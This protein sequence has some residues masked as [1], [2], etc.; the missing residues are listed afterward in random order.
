MAET[1]TPSA[2]SQMDTSTPQHHQVKADALVSHPIA[3]SPSMDIS[4]E[5][6]SLSSLNV[7]AAGFTPQALRLPAEGSSV[8]SIA[9]PAV[10]GSGSG[11]TARALHPVID[12]DS[13]PSTPEAVREALAAVHSL[14]LTRGMVATDRSVSCSG[15]GSG[16]SG[17]AGSPTS[18]VTVL[19]GS[20]PAGSLADTG[21]GSKLSAVAKEWVPPSSS[22]APAPLSATAAVSGVEEQGQ[23]LANSWTTDGMYAASDGY[24]YSSWQEYDPAHPSGGQYA[25]G[26]GQWGEARVQAGEGYDEEGYNADDFYETSAYNYQVVSTCCNAS[27]IAANV[28]DCRSPSPFPPALPLT[29][30]IFLAI[31]KFLFHCRTVSV[32]SLQSLQMY[33][34]A[35]MHIPRCR[36]LL[37]IPRRKQRTQPQLYS[38]WLSPATQQLLSARCY[39]RLTWTSRRL[40]RS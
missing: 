8:S 12:S 21:A 27:Y 19:P 36:P 38:P 7:R 15:D 29:A 18:P 35:D 3:P 11:S 17:S 33:P 32:Y 25:V 34:L 10:Q 28:Q 6:G 23:W 39:A 5:L 1:D 24:N 20:P 37:I 40:Q 2:P 9:A 31:F 16:F 13:E 4:A 22:A 14:A 26:A 30:W